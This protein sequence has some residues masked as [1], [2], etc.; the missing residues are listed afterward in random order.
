MLMRATKFLFGIMFCLLLGGCLT[1]KPDL[2]DEIKLGKRL[3]ETKTTRAFGPS[4]LN[5]R[6]I[7][8]ELSPRSQEKLIAGGLDYINALPS[9][10]KK[11]ANIKPPKIYNAE[12]HTNEE[13]TYTPPM[14]GPWTE[15][16]LNWNSAPISKKEDWLYNP[17]ATQ[18]AAN[19]P[20]SQITLNSYF[21][22]F[23]R[24]GGFVSFAS[25]IPAKWKSLYNQAR[26]DTNS[27]FAYGGYRGSN[28]V[29]ISPKM[30]LVFYLYSA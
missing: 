19:K 5:K 7:V 2:P 10:P 29:L 4:G 14:T 20:T 17:S 15:P 26:Q 30:G 28:V 18:R 12:G 13:G 22:N 21:G 23:I 6:F 24:E 16:F 27:L 1:V 8:F 3:S 9:I 11:R 25:I